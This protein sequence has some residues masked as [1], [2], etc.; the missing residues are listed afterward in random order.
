[1]LCD[2]VVWSKP[3]L[4]EF[5]K[6]FPS[7]KQAPPGYPLV[8]QHSNEISTLFNRKYSTSSNGPLSIAMLVYCRWNDSIYRGYEWDYNS[9]KYGYNPRQT[10]LFSAIYRGYPYSYRCQ[11][12]SIYND[13][14]G[15]LLVTCALPWYPCSPETVWKRLCPWKF[16]KAAS[17]IE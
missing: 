10:H 3:Y 12:H 7:N 17:P 11:C 6:H 14:L 16:I 1:M 5:P 2:H 4:G 13:R 15:A 8:N 9:Y